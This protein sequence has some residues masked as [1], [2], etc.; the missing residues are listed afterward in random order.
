MYAFCST[1][2]VAEIHRCGS[3]PLTARTVSLMIPEEHRRHIPNWIPLGRFGTPQD[4]ASG[5]LFLA[6]PHAA[7]ITGTALHIDGG[8]LAA[9]G[10]YRD[11]RGTWTNLPV[12]SGN[13]LN[14]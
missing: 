3:P 12:L 6:S 14:F 4:M 5:I 1:P 13:G 11:P 9:A 7:W 8:A 10:W 2:S